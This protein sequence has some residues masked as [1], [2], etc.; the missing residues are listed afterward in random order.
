M[1]VYAVADLHGRLPVVPDD[2]KT[3]LIAGDICPDHPIGKSERYSLPDKGASW[4][5]D[6]LDTVFRGWLEQ[7]VVRGVVIVAIWGNHDFI[8]EKML[9]IPSLPWFLLQDSETTVNGLRIYGTPWVPG[10]PRWAFYASEK[11]LLDRAESIPAGIDVLMS[12]GPPRTAGDRIPGNSKFNSTSDP[13]YVGDVALRD[14][15]RKPCVA[16]K[17]VI[18]GHIHEGRGSHSVAG[19]PVYNVA[20]VDENYNLRSNPCVRLYEF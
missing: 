19:V 13:I 4:Q 15:L 17:V 20:A 5:A 3:L 9:L 6:W 8:G 2:C 16:P 10:L 11:A 18:T 1:C 7:L 12:H 14:R